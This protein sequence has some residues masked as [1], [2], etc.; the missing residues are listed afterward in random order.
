[1]TYN[2]R[3]D[4]TAPTVTTGTIAACYPTVAAAE[5]AALAATSATDNCPG[6][7]TETA[8]TVGTCTAVVTVTTTDGC[9]NSATV[10]YN[11]R[12]DNVGPTVTP[13]T[14]A[15]CYSTVAAAEAA[16]LAATTVVD[17]CLSTTTVT[18][19]TTGTCN[20]V[21]T[22]TAV[23]G[24]GNSASTSYN[25]RIDNTP[26]VVSCK[27][28]TVTLNGN[29]VY[30]LT[31]GDVLNLGATSDNCGQYTVTMNPNSFSCANKN[32][33]FPVTVTVSDLCG[34]TSTCTS[35]ITVVEGTALPSGWSAGDVGT[36]AMGS[37]IY[38]P[39]INNGSFVLNAKG[40]STN[41][42]DVQHTVYQTLCGD[43][44]I[45]AHVAGLSPMGGW[46]GI[47]MRESSSQGSKKFT[48]KTQLSTILRREIRTSNFGVTNTLQSI[49]PPT[50]TWLRI[51]RSGNTFTAYS[52]PDGINWTF[53]SA[54]TFAMNSCIQVGLFVESYNNTTTTT[55]TIDNVMITGGTP[56]I[57][58]VDSG[59]MSDIPQQQ[60]KV[61]VYPNP[62]NGALM[63]DFSELIGKQVKVQVFNAQGQLVEWMKLDEARELEQLD[64]SPYS[65]G[66][67]WIRVQAE[68]MTP[69]TEK[70]FKTESVIRP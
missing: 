19:S 42:T 21:V 13:G 29:G 1:V 23:D 47:Q 32:Q 38:S 53:R 66:V 49:V 25:T 22:I 45:K 48:L 18:A 64:L 8:S 62:T 11:T 52:S 54:A 33:T 5:A 28:S 37:S 40:Y 26:P 43:A 60:A 3:I 55:A 68:G 34:N 44:E 58:L 41:T 6:T 36:N 50:H 24:C 12:I 10:T 30:V 51:T 17:D 20:A 14:I 31:S 15:A 61:K 59:D 67:Y 27:N 16:A 2:T 4:N 35:Q 65:E 69:V 63:L 46:A 56:P 7:L 57:P 9:G 39:C 70:I